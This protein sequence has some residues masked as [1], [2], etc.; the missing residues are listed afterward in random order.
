MVG[1]SVLAFQKLLEGCR[2]G[3]QLQVKDACGQGVGSVGWIYGA[4]PLEDDA[5]AVILAVGHMDGAA[6][7]G[8]PS[9][10]D[11]FVHVVPV[12]ALASELGQ[13]GW[14]NVNDP[15][16]VRGGDV[17]EVKIPGEDDPVDLVGGEEL[18]KAGLGDA[19]G[20]DL[21]IEAKVPGSLGS[22][23]VF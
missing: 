1:H 6:G 19:A 12:H 2:V 5:A 23:G 18:G 14:V 21:N 17:Q 15:A 4:S 13:E 20:D 22:G 10:E 11:C 9:F 16:P 8:F 3:F 7:G